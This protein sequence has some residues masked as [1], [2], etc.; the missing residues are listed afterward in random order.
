MLSVCSTRHV[1][2]SEPEDTWLHAA[3]KEAVGFL[4][5]LVQLGHC[6][7]GETGTLGES[8]RRESPQMGRRKGTQHSFI[9][10]QEIVV[11]R[12]GEAGPTGDRREEAVLWGS[13]GKGP[14]RLTSSAARPGHSLG[15]QQLTEVLV[16]LFSVQ[17]GH[18]QHCSPNTWLHDL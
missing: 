1:L 13:A 12:R 18:S 2:S 16:A 15:L 6:S 7:Q 14:S 11:L 4:Q 17:V 5:A 3:P 8:G 10:L 9:C